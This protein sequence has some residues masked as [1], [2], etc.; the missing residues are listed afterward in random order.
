MKTRIISILFS[1]SCCLIFG[2]CNDQGE[3]QMESVGPFFKGTIKIVIGNQND[4]P[5]L[6]KK[7]F[8]SIKSRIRYLDFSSTQFDKNTYQLT[9]NR[10]GDTSILK[11]LI[12]ES[13]TIE[14]TEVY[15]IGHLQQ[16][17]NAIVKDLDNQMPAKT[18]KDSNGPRGVLERPRTLTEIISFL[19]PIPDPKYQRYLY[20]A[21]I[22][23]VRTKDTAYLNNL[24]G[25]KKYQA[26]IPGSLRFAYGKSDSPS[27]ADSRILSLY[28][29]S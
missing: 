25:N 2:Y 5:N 13:L 22:G 14:F 10:S 8:S 26:F 1:T 7:T 15:T 20:P 6:I 17:F 16:L 28:A 27:T 4:D 11:K 3:N 23:N 12:A 18:V 24:L 9:I 29:L 19:Q 21:A